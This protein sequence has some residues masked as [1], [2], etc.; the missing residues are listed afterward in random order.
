MP[1]SSNAF[2]ET[3]DRDPGPMPARMRMLPLRS[4]HERAAAWLLVRGPWYAG[5][6]PGAV[7]QPTGDYPEELTALPIPCTGGRLMPEMTKNYNRSG[8]SRG[9]GVL[10]VLL[11]GLT[12]L[13]MGCEKK[14]GRGAGEA[15]RRR[16]GK[17]RRVRRCRS[18][19]QHRSEQSIESTQSESESGDGD[20]VM[21][22]QAAH[23]KQRSCII[24]NANGPTEDRRRIEVVALQLAY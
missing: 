10:A 4:S 19:A 13:T 1:C 3:K 21:T 11:M 8:M 6:V 9:V 2:V 5:D 15:A 24:Y 23:D 20:R 22:C 16:D 17:G 12:T 7:P 14:E 18:I